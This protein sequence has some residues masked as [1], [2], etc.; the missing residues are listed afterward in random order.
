MPNL[1][2]WLVAGLLALFEAAIVIT[3]LRMRVRTIGPRSLVGRRP[4]EIVWTLLPAL[5][6][7]AL[8]WLS[9]QPQ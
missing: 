7:V 2:F 5:L 9:L 3:A 4:A 1:S 8:V 6:L